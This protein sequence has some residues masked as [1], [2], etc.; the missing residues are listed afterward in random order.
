MLAS[1]VC[2][3]PYGIRG[4]IT[5]VRR[6]PR[7]VRLTVCSTPYGI[8]GLI[9]SIGNAKK[10]NLYLCSTPYGIRGLITRLGKRYDSL[11]SIKCSTPYGIRGLITESIVQRLPLPHGV[12][13]ALR[14]Q[15][16]DHTTDCWPSATRPAP[17]STPYGIRGLIT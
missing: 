14:H 12:L 10:N 8:R 5:T 3:T 2:S 1:Q 6:V 17:C 4:L 15:R 7:A 11:D 13:N 16:F 9:T